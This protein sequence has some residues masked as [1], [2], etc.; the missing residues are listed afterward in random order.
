MQQVRH[1]LP[2][3]RLV[4]VDDGFGEVSPAL[5]CDKRRVVM[6]SCLRWD[7]ALPACPGG[8]WV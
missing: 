8:L 2:G 6:V 7:T 5:A 1:W 3:R 4:L